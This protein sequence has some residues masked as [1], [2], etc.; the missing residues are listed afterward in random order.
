MST[1]DEL[2]FWAAAVLW[3]IPLRIVSLIILH[4]VISIVYGIFNNGKLQSEITDERESLIGYKST[5]N[6]YYAHSAGLLLAML[7]IVAGYS[8]PVMFTILLMSGIAAELAEYVSQFY[9]Y[10]KGV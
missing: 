8:V 3:L 2:K 9:Y 6:S 7:S 5:R 4:I 1:A 10:N